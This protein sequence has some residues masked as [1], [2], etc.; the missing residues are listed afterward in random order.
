MEKKDR[1]LIS[2]DYALKRLLRNKANYDV[3]EGFLSELLGDNVKV[4]SLVESGSNQTDITDKY[5]R[6]DILAESANEGVILIELQFAVEADYF[7]RML[8]GTGKA[9]CERMKQSDVYREVQKVYSVNIVYFD[10]GQGEDYVYHSWTR[11][12]GL[13][14]H[15]ELKLSAGQRRVFGGQV[16]G[17]IYP[18]YYILKINFFNDVV[19]EPL[20]EWIYFFKHNEIKAEFSA[21]GLQKARELLVLESL[22]PEERKEYDRLQDSRSRKLSE[23]AELESR[24]NRKNNG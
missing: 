5:N 18:E 17:Y 12:T 4:K 21:K 15:E 13:H 16:Q 8:F 10:S 6:V 14:T 19:K 20:D 11:F 2:F 3:L 24:I 7:Y 1:V 23:I 9:I 22:T